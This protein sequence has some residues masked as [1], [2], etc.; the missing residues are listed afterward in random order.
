MPTSRTSLAPHRNFRLRVLTR[1]KAA[2]I[3]HCPECNVLLDYEVSRNPNSAEPDH[4]V[5]HALGG[6][7]E[8]SNGRTICRQCN[9]SRGGK[10][11]SLT[12]PPPPKPVVSSPIW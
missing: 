5:P 1:D 7:N 4:I 11:A 3:T 6:T 10:T 12:P 9:Q 8:P 2:G